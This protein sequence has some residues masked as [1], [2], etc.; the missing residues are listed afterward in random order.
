LPVVYALPH[1]TPYYDEFPARGYE[2]AVYYY[3]V[4]FLRTSRGRCSYG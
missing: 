2:P 4:N 3:S 1:S